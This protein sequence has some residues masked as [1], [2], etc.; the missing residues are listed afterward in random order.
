MLEG[1]PVNGEIV[2]VGGFPRQERARV[3]FAELAP[4]EDLQRWYTALARLPGADS[5]AQFVPHVTLARSRRGLAVPRIEG[6]I[7]MTLELTAPA[8][9]ESVNTARGVCYRLVEADSG[10]AG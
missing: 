10:S 8:L 2:A 6:L 1:L 4:R 3:M 9:Y 7:G 5:A